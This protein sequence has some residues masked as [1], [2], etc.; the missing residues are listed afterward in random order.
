MNID[1]Y[2]IGYVNVS[3]NR[4]HV[5]NALLT[6]PCTSAEI[7]KQYNVRQSSISKAINDLKNNGMVAGDRREYKITKKGE[8]VIE[9]IDERNI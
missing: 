3:N 8:Q 7:A 2:D 1:F 6:K 9:A 4:K 5:L